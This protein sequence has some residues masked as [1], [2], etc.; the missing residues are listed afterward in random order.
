M[1]SIRHFYKCPTDDYLHACQVLHEVDFGLT[2]IHQ[3]IAKVHGDLNLF[4]STT[5]CLKLDMLTEVFWMKRAYYDDL[6]QSIRQ[7]LFSAVT[8]D[9]LEPDPLQMMPAFP[10]MP[11]PSTFPSMPDL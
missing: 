5:K 6:D 11:T 3:H 2:N 4:D 10:I 1:G 8:F 7:Y 9:R